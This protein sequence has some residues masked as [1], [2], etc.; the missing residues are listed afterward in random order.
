MPTTVI[1]K[2]SRPD[3]AGGT[4]KQGSTYTLADD[5]AAY[6]LS[7]G[8]AKRTSTRSEQTGA[9]ISGNA[10][11]QFPSAPALSSQVPVT[12]STSSDGGVEL[13]GGQRRIPTPAS[14]GSKGPIVVLG[15]PTLQA[16]DVTV[17]SGSGNITKITRRGLP[18]LQI[19]I[20]AGASNCQISINGGVNALYGGDIY[21][22]MEGNYR[23]G[24]LK[25][26]AY[27]APGATI[28][29]NYTF[30][31]NLSFVAPV[32]D[33]WQ[34]Q[35]GI[36]TWRSGRKN[37]SV[38][39]SIAY[40]FV[41]GS[42]KLIITPQAGQAATMYLYAVGYG[43]PKKG[44]LIV[45]A[46]DGEKSW[47]ALGAPL[48]NAA[49]I[50]TTAMIIPSGLNVGYGSDAQVSSYIDAG[51]C[52]GPHGPNLS[53]YA[54]NLITNYAT[55]AEAVSDI[56]SALSAIYKKGW[57][58][59]GADMIYAWPQGAF[60]RSFG[61]VEL[62]DAAYQYGIRLARCSSVINPL[63]QFVSEGASRLNRLA[64]PY[65]THGWAGTTAAQAAND[66]AIATAI[67]NAATYGTDV[68]LTYHQIV[69]DSTPDGSM[70]TIKCK[71]S[72]VQTHIAAA[73]AQVAAGKLDVMTLGQLARDI[74]SVPSYWGQLG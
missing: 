30:Q 57:Y 39:G 2:T 15:G 41:V 73:T 34:D 9:A 43:Q 45:M 46:D 14:G 3:G 51:N 50:P 71:V 55:A 22:A 44:R 29:T 72:S 36:Y 20:P 63:V 58:T 12:A 54:G 11:G 33:T 66:T 21:V 16:S 49:G 47:F 60:A 26:E 42:N 25:L 7:I 74:A 6:F 17:V 27:Q 31:G 1:M 37:I 35:G 61:D 48:W 13:W 18:C 32:K 67:E 53:S 59:P 24:L 5:L 40:P 68:F 8:A 64:L 28:A 23:T 4:Y 10:A 38:T 69:P 70:N 65:T 62:L 19:D 56:D 52:V